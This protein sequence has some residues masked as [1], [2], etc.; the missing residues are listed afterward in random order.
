MSRSRCHHWAVLQV[1]ISQTHFT[2]LHADMNDL[3]LVYRAYCESA[4]SLPFGCPV[5]WADPLISVNQPTKTE[6]GK[7]VIEIW[8]C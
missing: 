8:N 7:S 4:C 6:L 5:S 1:R 2:D 3:L